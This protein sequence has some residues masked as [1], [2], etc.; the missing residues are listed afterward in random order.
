MPFTTPFTAIAFQ[1]FLSSDWNTYIRD[2]LNFLKSDQPDWIKLG[3]TTAD[4]VKNANTTLSDVTGLS[5]SIAASEAWLF[6]MGLFVV[7]STTADLKLGLTFPAGATGRYG[8]DNTSNGADLI[9]NT[10]FRA[11][12]GVDFEHKVVSGLIVNSTTAGTFQL[13]AA[14]NTSHA[15]NTTIYENSHM[16]A[17]RFA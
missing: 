2:N 14:Q 13:Q 15:S 6:W 5:F 3:R 16:F 12:T 7:S 17:M 10:I 11:M 8:I 4:F 9:A 1:K